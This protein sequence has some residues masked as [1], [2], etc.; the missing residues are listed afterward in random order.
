MALFL[1]IFL[2]V[3]GSAHVFFL[4][5]MGSA[6]PGLRQRWILPAGWCLLMLVAPL[7]VRTLERSGQTTPALIAAYTGYCWMGFLFLFISLSAA[8]G[9]LNL[10][11]RAAK[12]FVRMPSVR[13]LTPRSSFQLCFG[14]AALITCYAW[15]EAADLKTDYLTVKTPK[16]PQG[17]S[18]IRVVQ[19]SDLHIG[20]IVGHRQVQQVADAVEKVKPDLLVATGDIVDGHI[21]HFDGVSQMLRRLSPRLGKYAVFGNHEYYVGLDQSRS[22]LEQSGFSILQNRTALVCSGLALAGVDDPAAARFGRYQAV[23]ERVLLAAIPK[24]RFVMLLKHRPVV[25]RKSQGLFDLQLSGHVHK[26]QIFPFNLLTWLNF[27]VRAGLNRLAEG[28]LLYV[29]RGTGTWGPPLRF[30][31]PPELTVIDL[32]PAE[33]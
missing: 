16:L 32:V 13:F 12:Y 24:D 29:S 22:F 19:I 1:I 17:A 5:R 4:L 8:L 23:D 10:L 3:Y 14:L 30:L 15:F 28:G 25:E 27:P 21:K 11:Y 9:V 26:G 2:F 20:L 6:W 33:N 7:L 31:A 18:P